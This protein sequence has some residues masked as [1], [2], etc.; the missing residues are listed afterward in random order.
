MC[1]ILDLTT[2]KQNNYMLR[3]G[4]CYIT[5]LTWNKTRQPQ[6]FCSLTK[7]PGDYFDGVVWNTAAFGATT[8]SC[9]RSMKG[10]YCAV[11]LQ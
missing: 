5:V 3:I 1:F 10:R 2:D 8:E 11:S 6:E 9:F 7:G 4:L